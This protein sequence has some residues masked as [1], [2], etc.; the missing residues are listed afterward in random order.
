M[1]IRIWTDLLE[2]RKSVVVDGTELSLLP[3]RCFLPPRNEPA[4]KAD[5]KKY[6][7]LDR[8]DKRAKLK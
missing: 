5:A 6:I 8:K 3:P 1:K 7:K 2:Q 4:K